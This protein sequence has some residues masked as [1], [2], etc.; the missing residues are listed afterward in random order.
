MIVVNITT[1][2]P[3]LPAAAI[4]AADANRM[5]SALLRRARA[6]H[7]IVITSHGRPVARLVP[8]RE[9]DGVTQTARAGLFKRLRATPAR[10][11]RRWTRDELYQD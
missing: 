1:K 5:F 2:E 8:V 9:G 11:V 3:G 7:T 6:G 10:V 4:P